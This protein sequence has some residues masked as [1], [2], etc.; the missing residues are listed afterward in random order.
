MKNKNKPNDIILDKLILNSSFHNPFD[1]DGMNYGN[2]N[3]NNR[4]GRY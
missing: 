3:F 1:S 4:Y 2:N